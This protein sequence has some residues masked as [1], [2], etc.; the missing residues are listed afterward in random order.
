MGIRV[1][2]PPFSDRDGDRHPALVRDRDG[3]LRELQGLR[4]GSSAITQQHLRLPGAVRQNLDLA[5]AHAAH[6]QAQHLAD[7]LLGSPATRDA[8]GPTVAV[9]I[10]R[11]GQDAATESVGVAA[12]DSHDPI[13]VDEVDPH[14]VA[15]HY[16]TVTD[17]ARFLGWSTSVPRATATS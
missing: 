11:L 9:A 7:R 12:Q 1:P 2:L 4:S 10:L 3:H 13:D 14:L 5:P 16:S 6:A 15:A 17:F 8:L